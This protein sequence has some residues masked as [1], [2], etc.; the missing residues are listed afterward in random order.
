MGE[1]KIVEVTIENFSFNPA[2]VEILTG[3]TVRWKNEDSVIHTVRGS[4]FG[5]GELKKGDTYDFLFT[6]AGT[7]NYNCSIHPSMKGTVVV[8]EK[9]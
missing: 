5:S 6:D 2:S 3:D 7:Y 4:A 8:N 9:N 1:G